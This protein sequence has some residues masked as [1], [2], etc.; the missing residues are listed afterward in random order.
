MGFGVSVCM[1]G[2]F[3][4]KNIE[5]WQGFMSVED[6]CNVLVARRKYFSKFINIACLVPVTAVIRS[7]V[8]AN[9]NH[10]SSQSILFYFFLDKGIHQVI[11]IGCGV[12]Y[13]SAFL[14]IKYQLKV[15]A[16]DAS[17]SNIASTLKKGKA[18]KVI[19]TKYSTSE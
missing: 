3:G 17:S 10:H 12:G 6:V 7:L 15:L 18:F 4:G 5:F 8:P 2:V 19:I 14:L 11:D 1:T 16:V 9:T 13:L